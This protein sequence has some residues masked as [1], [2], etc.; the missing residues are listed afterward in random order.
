MTT[1]VLLQHLQPLCDLP[2]SVCKHDICYHGKCLGYS[3]FQFL[4]A[5][6]VLKTLV[7]TKPKKDEV[8]RGY[9]WLALGPRRR[10]VPSYSLVFGKVSSKEAWTFYPQCRTLILYGYIFKYFLT[11]F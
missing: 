4:Q 1:P 5:R 10:S 2:P 3:G 11:T 6:K 7:M 8:Q 9:V